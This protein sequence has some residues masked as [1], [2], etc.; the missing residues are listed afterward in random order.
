[1]KILNAIAGGGELLTPEGTLVEPLWPA[2]GTELC[3]HQSDKDLFGFLQAFCFPTMSDGSEIV[4][5]ARWWVR[6]TSELRIHPQAKAGTFAFRGSGVF[7][8]K[9]LP[10][11][12][13]RYELDLLI[14]L[15]WR[16]LYNSAEVDGIKRYS[17]KQGINQ[18]LTSS[19]RA[20]LTDSMRRAQ[21]ELETARRQVEQNQMVLAVL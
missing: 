13:E 15:L 2:N 11:G 16:D 20:S 3:P 12:V 7:F 10:I 17:L 5:S 21:E 14:E 4:A 1:M 8:W 6:K 19:L 9:M 18:I